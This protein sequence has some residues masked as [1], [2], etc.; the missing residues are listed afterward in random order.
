MPHIISLI[1]A[2][3][4]DKI[5]YKSL[6]F[7]RGGAKV[8]LKLEINKIKCT[9]H[10]E[11]NAS[12]RSR[13]LQVESSDGPIVLDFSNEPGQITIKGKQEN[14]DPKW[15]INTG[16]LSSMLKCFLEDIERGENTDSRFSP[17]YGQ[18]ACE[19]T[20]YAYEDYRLLQIDWLGTAY[21]EE[22]NKDFMYA[23]SELI[24]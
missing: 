7:E 14:A 24:N 17:A 10:L 4:N 11:R 22:S 9:V 8:K 13:L 2:I 23:Y 6:V 12:K 18:E 1:R 16:P 5:V 19:I 15:G 21:L 3:S 20:D